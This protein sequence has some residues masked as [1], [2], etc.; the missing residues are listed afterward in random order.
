MATQS[1][2]WRDKWRFLYEFWIEKDFKS[3]L[4]ICKTEIITLQKKENGD[5]RTKPHKM[6]D[7]V[8]VFRFNKEL[9][10]ILI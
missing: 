4:T 2:N 7:S 8:R 1:G 6:G 3:I 9:L 10:P 5:D